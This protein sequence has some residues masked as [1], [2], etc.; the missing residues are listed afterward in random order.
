[1]I[2]GAIVAQILGNYFIKKIIDIKV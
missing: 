1:M 2:G